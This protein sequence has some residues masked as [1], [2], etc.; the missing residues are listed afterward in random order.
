MVREWTPPL[1]S[2]LVPTQSHVLGTSPSQPGQ[3]GQAEAVQSA[4]AVL[5]VQLCCAHCSCSVLCPA[6]QWPAQLCLLLFTYCPHAGAAARAQLMIS[7]SSQQVLSLQ[8]QA[9]LATGSK[10]AHTHAVLQPSSLPSTHAL[11]A[12]H[13]CGLGETQMALEPYFNSIHSS[14]ILT[15]PGRLCHVFWIR[16]TVFLWQ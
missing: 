2:R 5:S 11:A 1:L 4:P 16:S 8:G 6:L 15:L 13:P 7:P 3:P 14:L 12:P 9:Q 10:D